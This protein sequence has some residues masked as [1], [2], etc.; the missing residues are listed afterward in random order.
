MCLRFVLI[1]HGEIRRHRKDCHEGRNVCTHRPLETGGTA[2]YTRPQGKH[3][4]Q[5]GGRERG[6][7]MARGFI[8]VSTSRQ[9]GDRVRRFR[10]GS[11]E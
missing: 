8:V 10:V 4:G 6:A 1:R 9:R 3:Q 7:N 11:F 2:R 5:S